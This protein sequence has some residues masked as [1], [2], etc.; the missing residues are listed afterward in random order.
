M[1]AGAKNVGQVQQQQKTTAILKSRAIFKTVW[2]CLVL[3]IILNNLNQE[4]SLKYKVNDIEN[5]FI[6]YVNE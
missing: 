5:C 1:D 2:K 4:Y 3:T 6:I